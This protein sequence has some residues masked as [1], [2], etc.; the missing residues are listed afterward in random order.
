MYDVWS[1]NIC[2]ATQAN[3]K[4]EGDQRPAQSDGES[5]ASKKT[6]CHRHVTHESSVTNSSAHHSTQLEV[7]DVSQATTW[8]RRKP[9]VV[10]RMETEV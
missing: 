7:S 1:N 8:R 3:M 6:N 2:Y 10:P 9:S 4:G 5:E